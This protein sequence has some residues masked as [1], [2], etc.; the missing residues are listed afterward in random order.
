MSAKMLVHMDAD[1]LTASIRNIAEFASKSAAREMRKA[2]IKIR[3]L[4]RDYAPE[5]TRNLEHAIDWTSYKDGSTH[6]NVFVVFVNESM[7]KRRG[8]NYAELMEE[9]LE[10]YGSG[11]YMPGE[12]SIK[13]MWTGKKVG[14]RFLQ[15]AADDG[16]K[17][18]VEAA[19]AAVARALGG[20]V[21]GKNFDFDD[22][23]D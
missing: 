23:G 18:A 3:D 17:G 15:R 11:R 22:F 8:A 14:G 12:Q 16:L 10:P 7:V 5:K 4:A 13:K 1:G 20:F 9:G 21:S 19:N 6:R 2:A